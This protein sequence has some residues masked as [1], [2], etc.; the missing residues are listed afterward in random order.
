LFHEAAHDK[1]A[2]TIQRA[3]TSS[4][5][6]KL[7]AEL[8]VFTFESFKLT[9]S[10][11][12]SGSGDGAFNTTVG[13]HNLVLVVFSAVTLANVVRILF[14]AVSRDGLRAA[15]CNTDKRMW[16]GGFG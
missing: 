2:K 16:N 15:Y 9:A 10:P 11:G 4:D 5:T 3:T 7:K 13:V 1:K 14:E 8:D 12:Y 6:S